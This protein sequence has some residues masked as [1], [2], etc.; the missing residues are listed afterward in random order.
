MKK[1]KNILIVDDS[2]LARLTL[3]RLLRKRDIEVLE[4]SS[5]IDGLKVLHTEKVDAVFMDVMMPERDGFEGLELIKSNHQF[6]HI[7]CSMYSSDI[8]YEAQKKAIDSG[9]QAYLFKPVC[10]EDIDNVLC[11]LEKNIIAEDMRRVIEKGNHESVTKLN[12]ALMV[13]DNR[14][15]NLAKFIARDRKTID[16]N[17][18]ALLKQIGMVLNDVDKI[19]NTPDCYE[20]EIADRK[21]ADNELKSQ[22]KVLRE[23]VRKLIVFSVFGFFVAAVAIFIAAIR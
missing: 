4:A 17:Q 16:N 18:K 12:Q 22:I 9:A 23:T 6:E 7:P 1:L 15:R 5:V 11:A 3:S 19:K 10:S 21:R 13:L 2:K 8:S 20:R 14:T